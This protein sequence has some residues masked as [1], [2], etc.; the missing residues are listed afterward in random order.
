MSCRHKVLSDETDMITVVCFVIIAFTCDDDCNPVT[1]A[2]V[3]AIHLFYCGAL[4]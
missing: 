1:V 3:I 4:V 2:T